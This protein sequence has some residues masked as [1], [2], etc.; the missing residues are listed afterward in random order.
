MMVAMVTI[1][2]IVMVIVMVIV[3]MMMIMIM[4]MIII[5]MIVMMMIIIMIM[6]MII[7]VMMINNFISLV[8]ANIGLGSK[9]EWVL[10][11][12]RG[13]LHL[14]IHFSG[15]NNTVDKN[16]KNSHNHHK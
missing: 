16:N 5:V 8:T 3:V 12:A 14:I 9:P 1:I 13:V 6:M 7:I 10:W 4:M 15:D 11:I 2:M